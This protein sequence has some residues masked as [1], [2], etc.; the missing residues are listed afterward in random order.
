MK[1]K[2]RVEEANEFNFPMLEKLIK[3]KL[4]EN[5]KKGYME[6]KKIIPF[7]NPD[8]VIYDLAEKKGISYNSALC[9]LEEKGVIKNNYLTEEA[10]TKGYLKFQDE[11][12]LYEKKGIVLLLEIS[13][14][15]HFK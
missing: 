10:F 4:G 3:Q 8:D 5:Y 7:L 2:I 13:D 6:G 1:K 12:L 14:I 9:Q 15:K 11:V